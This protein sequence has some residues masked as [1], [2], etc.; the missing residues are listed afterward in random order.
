MQAASCGL[1]SFLMLSR[2]MGKIFCT[3]ASSCCLNSSAGYLASTC[4]RRQAQK[5]A[6][7]EPGKMARMQEKVITA[8]C[9]LRA[10]AVCHPKQREQQ[11]T[12]QWTCAHAN[13][14]LMRCMASAGSSLHGRQVGYACLASVTWQHAH[15]VARARVAKQMTEKLVMRDVDMHA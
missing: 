9:P 3:K 10:A 11:H 2:S 7:A 14:R 6:T 15:P 1:T 8:E 5:G 12:W 13:V 4:T